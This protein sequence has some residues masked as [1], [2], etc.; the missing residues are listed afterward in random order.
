MLNAALT[1]VLTIASATTCLADAHMTPAQK[2]C[3]A[4]MHGDCGAMAIETGCCPPDSR[5]TPSI[6]SNTPVAQR[7]G[8]AAPVDI[9]LIPLPP[10][11]ES[12]RTPTPTFDWRAAKSTSPPTYL[13]H[14]VFRI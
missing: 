2:A 7:I 11:L 12:L 1:V 4:E 3:C 8:P 6:L 9:T 13:L 5:T 14:T 10:V